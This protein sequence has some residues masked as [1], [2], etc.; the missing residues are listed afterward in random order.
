MIGA[1]LAAWMQAALPTLAAALVAAILAFIVGVAGATASS[2]V[3]P[4]LGGLLSRAAEMAGSLPTLLLLAL[5]RTAHPAPGLALTASVVGLLRGFELA[6]TI[7][8]HWMQ[9]EATDFVLAARALGSGPRRIFRR[10]LWPH[11]GPPAIA[12]AALTAPALVG[13]D[14]ALA[15]LGLESDSGVSWGTLLGRAARTAAPGAAL[16]PAAGAVALV[17]ALLS[18]ARRIDSIHETGRRF[19]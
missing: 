6:H 11:L 1:E 15:A 3:H 16:L 9:L 17:A 14:A 19:L 7:R 2:G 8:A 10:E 12:H 18:V 5:V 13:V 4:L